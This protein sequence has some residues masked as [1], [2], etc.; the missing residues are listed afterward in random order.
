MAEAK[1][2]HHHRVNVAPAVVQTMDL[3][4]PAGKP[5][6]LRAVT[7]V[8]TE[9]AIAATAR[10]AVTAAI[11][12]H[13][14]VALAAWDRQENALAAAL[15]RRIPKKWHRQAELAVAA[16]LRAAAVLKAVV[17][18]ALDRHRAKVLLAAV[19]AAVAP[20]AVWLEL[21]V[22]A[23]QANFPVRAP[24]NAQSA[25]ARSLTSPLADST[26]C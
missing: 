15:P 19:A 3:V 20:Q 7:E 13:Y 5:V 10:P 12:G 25:L 17:L 21:A 4:A 14:R 26:K 24:K 2:C 9:T 6:E 22:Q 18:V 1:V 23:V 11:Q 16:A 8:L